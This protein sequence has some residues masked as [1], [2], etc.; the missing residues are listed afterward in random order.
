MSASAPGPWNLDGFT[1][2]VCTSITTDAS[3]PSKQAS[4]V[5]LST[6]ASAGSV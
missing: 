3:P 5:A 1:R 6:S 2:W 4:A